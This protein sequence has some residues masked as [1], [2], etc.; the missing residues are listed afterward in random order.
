[1]QLKGLSYEDFFNL[2]D[3]DHNG[4]ITITEFSENVDKVMLLSQPAKDGFFAFIDKQK[5]GLID[6]KTFLRFV[7]KSIVQKMP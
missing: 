7:G 5:I 1:M 2:L 6:M 3:S 4:F